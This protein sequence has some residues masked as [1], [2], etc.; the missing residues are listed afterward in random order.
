MTN[1]R[2]GQLSGALAWLPPLGLTAGI[3]LYAAAMAYLEAA[4]VVYLRAALGLPTG[5]VFPV[6]L[7][8]EGNAF[9]L[10][11]V[12]REA[13]TLVMIGGVAW[14]AGRESLERLA[15]AGV[16]FGIWDI[17]YYAWLWVLSGWPPSFGTWDLLFLLPLPWT[18]PVWAP[19]AVSAALVGFGLAYAGRLRSGRSVPFTLLHFGA[20]VLAGAVVIVSFV[21]NAGVVRDGGAPTSFAWP[22]FLGGM[23]LGLAAA[24]LP[25][26]M[27]DAAG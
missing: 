16:V 9:G 3:L 8:P 7:S 22:V 14:V 25:L 1:G 19:I 21:L 2:S 6:N 18:G 11:E 23:A 20:L 12:G 5:S 13:A 4:V 10:I 15:W 17:G 24:W 26:R 27:R